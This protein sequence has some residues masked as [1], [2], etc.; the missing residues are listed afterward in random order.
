MV[1]GE[2]RGWLGLLLLGYIFV[3]I[4]FFGKWEYFLYFVSFLFIYFKSFSLNLL[5]Y[6]K[7][8][9]ENIIYI[10]EKKNILKKIM[11]TNMI[12]LKNTI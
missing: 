3:F 8:S 5:L 10:F 4:F 2:K 1:G 7:I 12:R 6:S 9:N 11:E